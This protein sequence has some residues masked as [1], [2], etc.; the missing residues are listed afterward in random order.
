LRAL[1]ARAAVA[2]DVAAL[3]AA[4]PALAGVLRYGDVR[5]SDRGA[6]RRVAV[7][8][9][10][11]ATVSLPQAGIGLDDEAAG[12][13][14]G[15]V[16]A[17]HSGLGL[18]DD[19]GLAA[20]WRAALRKVAS[21]D[22]QPGVLAGRA[23]RLLLDGGAIDPDEA[24]A[25]MSRALSPGGD[26]AVGAAWIEGFLGTSGLVLVHDAALLALL[27][28]WVA[29]VPGD[30]FKAVLPLLRRSFGALP[31]GERRQIGA[32]VREGAGAATAAA[33]G[34]DVDAERA[35]PALALVARI[36]GAGGHAASGG[37][38]VGGDRP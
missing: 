22:R 18:L 32:R 13:L 38:S 28:E 12:Q 16:D 26:T 20:D 31:A 10:R 9:V 29:G 2:A 34:E 33:G 14:S 24:A 11:R 21:G 17:A 27:D 7:G 35:A 6:V 30:A 23:T 19:A 3:L 37:D 5:G 15:L 8:L 4:V 36:L 1:E 25:A